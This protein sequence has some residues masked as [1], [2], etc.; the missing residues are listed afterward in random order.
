MRQGLR[1]ASGLAKGRMGED[2]AEDTLTKMNRQ[3]AER[4]MR[5]HMPG[6]GVGIQTITKE[7]S[8]LREQASY[9]SGWEAGGRKAQ[10]EIEGLKIRLEQALHQ[11]IYWRNKA[12]VFPTPHDQVRVDPPGW[13]PS[14]AKPIDLDSMRYESRSSSDRAASKARVEQEPWHAG[15][16]PDEP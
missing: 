14:E 15:I 5:E 16:D 7:E 4:Y 10:S 9:R 3:N 2:M 6:S 13:K 8:A 12:Q 11:L 1:L